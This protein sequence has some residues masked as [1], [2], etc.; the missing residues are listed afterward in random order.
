MTATPAPSPPSTSEPPATVGN[1]PAPLLFDTSADVLKRAG[2]ES[3]VVGC[4]R[5]GGNAVIVRYDAGPDLASPGIADQVAQIVWGSEP[6]RFDLLA[7]ESRGTTA[8]FSYSDLEQRF[9]PQPSGSESSA[10]DLCG[11]RFDLNFHIDKG[12]EGA[13]A[14]AIIVLA[15]LGIVGVLGWFIAVIPKMIAGRWSGRQKPRK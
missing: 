8:A 11:A 5:H 3:P 14:F 15:A 7:V 2:F 10:Q 13:A 12:F 1:P 6:Y 4:P 9:G